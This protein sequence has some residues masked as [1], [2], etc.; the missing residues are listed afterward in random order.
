MK[1]QLKLPFGQ[2]VKQPKPMA[3]GRESSPIKIAELKAHGIAAATTLSAEVILELGRRYNQEPCTVYGA[4][5][6]PGDVYTTFKN[7]MDGLPATTY[8]VIAVN[9]K[10]MVTVTKLFPSLPTVRQ[11]MR[12]AI[13]NSAA[14]FFVCRNDFGTPE[15]N[16]GEERFIA[17]MVDA[18][19]IIGIDL[20][21][22]MVMGT[23]GFE[24]ARVEHLI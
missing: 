10:H 11:I 18:G 22:F 9:M 20:L 5:Q 19:D 16:N 23:F 3:A 4:L 8:N 21:D 1:S 17:E 7:E 2:P 6:S 15:I 12:W 13:S 24:S 14:A